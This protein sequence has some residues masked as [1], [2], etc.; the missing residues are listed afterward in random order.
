MYLDNL[1]L[2][3]YTFLMDTFTK[4]DGF[5]SQRILIVPD[6]IIVECE[7]DPLIRP[8]YVSDIGFFPHA[9]YHYRQRP[10]GAPAHILIYCSGGKGFFTL[11]NGKRQALCA[12]Q[13]LVI[14][15]E[16]PHTYGADP[17]EPWDI[18]WMHVRGDI[19]PALLDTETPSPRSLP[20][21]SAAKWIELFEELYHTL[22]YG[23]TR[24]NLVY[25]SQTLA[26]LLGLI[27]LN[28]AAGSSIQSPGNRHAVEQV[29]SYLNARLYGTVTLEELCR[30]TAL[31]APRLLAV[32]RQATGYSPIHYFH[33]LKIQNCCKYL[34]LTDYPI[35]EIASKFGFSDPYY[36][37]RLFKK[38]MGKS[39][40]DYRNTPKG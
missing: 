12:G 33:R 31:S 18:Y 28:A 29:I 37:S 10:E 20:L 22:E 34:D 1:V 15:P 38:I 11:D 7:I 3:A 25:T 2:F 27:Y 35:K 14:P 39:P 6:N 16:T 5:K 26:H 36:F 30:Q 4:P 9:Q 19:L 23:F 8:A 32:F 21:D 17:D 40:R 13:L 24:P